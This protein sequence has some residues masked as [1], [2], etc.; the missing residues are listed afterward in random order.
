MHKTK[1]LLLTAVSIFLPLVCT[2]QYNL[3]RIDSESDAWRSSQRVFF[4]NEMSRLLM[5]QATAFGVKC[6]PSFS[7]EW[8][9]TYDSVA[10]VLVYNKAQKS[11][12]YT[13][14]EAMHK[15]KTK[16][17][18][19]SNRQIITSKLRKKPKDYQAPEV[20]TFSLAVSDDQAAMLRAIWRNAVYN[21]EDREVNILDGTKWEYF[22]DGRRAKS[23]RDEN[24]LVKFTNELAKAV[25]TGNDARKDSLI[26]S[27]FQRVVSNLTITPQPL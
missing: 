21:A 4:D 7:P 22:I 16:I 8:T 10:H 26:G 3:I 5:P 14:Y 18:K 1:K 19:A 2:A 12:W 24:V 13:T 6:I 11:V 9:L 25:S 15:R 20:D 17:D 23:H 27:E